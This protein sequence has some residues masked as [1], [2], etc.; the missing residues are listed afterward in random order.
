MAVCVRFGET[1]QHAGLTEDTAKY[2]LARDPEILA[3]LSDISQS[4]LSVVVDPAH[5]QTRLIVTAA[6]LMVH[7]TEAGADLVKTRRREPTVARAGLPRP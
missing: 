1:G 7:R 5:A 3:K 2:I 4:G 6:F